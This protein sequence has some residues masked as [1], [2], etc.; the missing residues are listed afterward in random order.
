MLTVLGTHMQW[1]WDLT[2]RGLGVEPRHGGGFYVSH[3]LSHIFKPPPGSTGQ[4]CDWLLTAVSRVLGCHPDYVI[5]DC[6]ISP[7]SKLSSVGFMSECLCWGVHRAGKWASPPIKKESL[8]RSLCAC[9]VASVV[10]DSLWP[11]ELQPTRLLC[12]WDSPGKNAEGGCRAL[13]QGVFPTQGSNPFLFCLLHWQ[14]GSLPPAPP[15]KPPSRKEPSK[16][17]INHQNSVMHWFTQQIPIA[18]Y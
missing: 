17:Q 11:Q 4:T 18:S 15:G 14:V 2:Q 12:P 8:K 1:G 7:T 3:L 16:S 13:L 6:H 9:R 5:K 10:P